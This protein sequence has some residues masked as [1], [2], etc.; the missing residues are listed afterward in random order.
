MFERAASPGV[1]SNVSE[2]TTTSLPR[3]VKSDTETPSK[4]QPISFQNAIKKI[5]SKREIKAKDRM[6][7]DRFKREYVN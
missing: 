6:R 3:I 5:K 4:K 7:L 1:A 2:R